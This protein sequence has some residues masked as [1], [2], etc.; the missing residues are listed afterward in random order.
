MACRAA[1]RIAAVRAE[2]EEKQAG[3][4]PPASARARGRPLGAA[5]RRDQ[6][7]HLLHVRLPLRHPRV[8]QGRQGPLHRGQPRPPREQGR[9]VR[10]GRGRHHAAL[11]AGAPAGAA[12]ARRPARL[13]RLPGDLLGRGPGACDA[14]GWARC[15]APTPRSSPSSPAATRASRSRAGGPCSSARP[16]LRRT[17]ASARSTWRPPACTPSAARSGSSAT[18]TGTARATS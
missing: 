2:E 11:F 14:S 15:A 3:E 18:P 12:A 4:A 17:A 5:G 9:A 16:T 10:Q 1:R 13:R 7:H 8:P 6:D